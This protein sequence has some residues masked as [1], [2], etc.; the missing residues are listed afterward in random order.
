MTDARKAE[1]SWGP[2]AWGPRVQPAQGIAFNPYKLTLASLTYPAWKHCMIGGFRAGC[3]ALLGHPWAALAWFAASCAADVFFQGMIGVWTRKAPDSGAVETPMKVA[4]LCAFRGCLYISGPLVVTLQSGHPEDFLF[5]T[6]MTWS[7]VAFALSYGAFSQKVFWG[8]AL[9]SMLGFAFLG[10][11]MLAPLHAAV[12]IA[13]TVFTAL[14]MTMVWL[15]WRDAMAEWRRTHN[16]SLEMIRDLEATRDRAVAERGA[17]DEAREAARRAGQAK[18]N[19]LAAM[20]HE[21][22]TPMNGVLGMA[23]V[24][25]LTAKDPEQ[26]ESLR[27]LTESGEHLLTIL[28]D[29]LDMSKVD[30]GRLDLAFEPEDL[31]RFL[32]QLIVFWGAQA[33]AK[34]LE[35]RLQADET[36][37][38]FVV[39]DAV[40]LRQV[41]FN[42][43]GNALKFTE[44]GSVNIAAR[45]GP[46]REGRV[47]L[48]LAISDTGPGISPDALPMLFERFSQVE[49]AATRRHGGAGLGLAI[50]KQITELMGGRIRAESTLGEG[51][52]F[53]IDL[54]LEVSQ[55]GPPT[56]RD[57]SDDDE[58]RALK[59]LAVDDNAVNLQVVERMLAMRDHAVFKAASGVEALAMAAEQTF[60]VVLMDIHMPGMSGIEVLKELRVRAGPNRATPVIA[61]TADV[62]S[63]GADRYLRLGFSEY[64]T[65]PLQ[66]RVLFNA[67]ARAITAP[68]PRRARRG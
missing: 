49:E 57:D 52:T 27:T 44:H 54:V 32:E 20:S 36:L 42:L 19:F 7:T 33:Q 30:S 61:L 41:L 50:C 12:I 63:G 55:T 62:T 37:P 46:A 21:I 28:N 51:T 48:S 15:T 58:F 39:M 26:V 22:R 10:A 16:A 9:P 35:L 5:L 64:T 3:L 60:D 53:H 40:R 25:R 17:A 66:P 23:E 4:L 13:S 67:I 2:R 34:G 24:L 47:R 8:M 18:A 6:L 1:P 68:P 59:I 45:A 43:I 56:A 11:R 29:I 65:K 31:P 38:R 14:V